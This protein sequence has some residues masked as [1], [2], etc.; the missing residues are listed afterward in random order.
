MPSV[1]VRLP[2]EEKANLE[3]VSTLR[4]ARLAGVS[5]GLDPGT[6]EAAMLAGVLAHADADDRGVRMT[7]EMR[8]Q[9]LGGM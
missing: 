1:S 4:A 6:P 9:V 5:L 7:G 2:E 3:E 8:E